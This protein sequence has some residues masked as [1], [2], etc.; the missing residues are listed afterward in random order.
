MAELKTKKKNRRKKHMKL[1]NGYGSIV[2]LGANRR[3]PYAIYPPVTLYAEGAPVRS[4]AIGY[5]E[6]YYAAYEMLVAWKNGILPEHQ[7]LIPKKKKGLTFSEVYERFYKDKFE[8]NT[9]RKYS[10]ATQSSTKVAYKN[11]ISLHDKEFRELRYEDLQGVVDNCTLKHASLELIVSLIKQMYKYALKYDLCDRNYSEYLEIKI[12]DDDEHGIPFSDEELKVLWQHKENDIIAMLLIMIYSGYRI[13]AW[14]TMT[15]NTQEWYFQGGIKTVA[16]KN[17]IVPI[18]SKIQPLVQALINKHG[19][20]LCI[21]PNTFRVKMTMLLSELNFPPHTP[22][23]CR[24]TFSMLCEQY[25]V[26]EN[27]RKR[28]LGHAF[29]DITNKV[30]GHR[31]LDD[32]RAEIEK[33]RIPE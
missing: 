31:T 15:V 20:L 7:A 27:D 9:S 22:H 8:I 6:D 33:I 11:C 19:R 3:R 18:H 4:K 28:M 17:R 25:N 2:Y 24:H 12:P 13:G 30:Y 16:G 5:A 29:D 23:D 32:L 10:E 26:A 14:K 21:T 1:P